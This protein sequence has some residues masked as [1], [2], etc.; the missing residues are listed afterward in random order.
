M[1]SYCAFLRGISPGT[2]G[3]DALRAAFAGLGFENVATLL[4][5]GNVLFTSGST[6]SAAEL[7]DRIQDALQ[8]EC[9]IGGGTLL[10]TADELRELSA[11]R[12]FG[13]L[14]H[15]KETYLTATFV[16][17]ERAFGAADVALPASPIPHVRLLGYDKTARV[18][19]AVVDQT[20]AKAS[21]YMAWLERRFGTDITTRTWNTVTK[22]RARLDALTA[23]QP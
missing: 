10:R 13:D 12:P 14:A 8:R 11:R 23:G 7:E 17:P 19:L 6:L 2:P 9:G 5:S 22:L 20:K 15:S 21:N 3:N 16:G 18:V 4:A 1:T